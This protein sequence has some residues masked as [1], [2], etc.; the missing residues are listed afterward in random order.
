LSWIEIF[1]E[2]CFSE[3]SDVQL[4]EGD[5]LPLSHSVKQNCQVTSANLP[6][7]TCGLVEN[8][9]SDQDEDDFSR[10]LRVEEAFSTEFPLKVSA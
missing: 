2:N 4:T 3:K 9:F 5:S 8:S 1:V 7:M 10:G 6:L